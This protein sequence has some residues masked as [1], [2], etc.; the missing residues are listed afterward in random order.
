MS[1]RDC[2]FEFENILKTFV[3]VSKYV[4][5]NLCRCNFRTFG[6][7]DFLCGNYGCGDWTLASAC[8]GYISYP[9]NVNLTTPLMQS[10]TGGINHFEFKSINYMDW[11]CGDLIIPTVVSSVPAI[12]DN[13]SKS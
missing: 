12:T 2:R 5:F 13:S 10:H 6:S 1:E 7:L 11:T 3:S 8:G 9:Y 4:F